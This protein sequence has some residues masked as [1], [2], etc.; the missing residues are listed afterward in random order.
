MPKMVKIARMVVMIPINLTIGVL[1]GVL[2]G[3]VYWASELHSEFQST[4][5]EAGVYGKKPEPK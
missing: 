3:I 2:A 1:A 4:R 5:F